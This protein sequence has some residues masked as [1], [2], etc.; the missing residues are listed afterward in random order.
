MPTP[1]CSAEEEEEEVVWQ[2]VIFKGLILALFKIFYNE[3]IN[4]LSTLSRHTVTTNF[5]PLLKQ[6]AVNGF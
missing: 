3:N 2:G 4:H 6:N 5:N 1:S